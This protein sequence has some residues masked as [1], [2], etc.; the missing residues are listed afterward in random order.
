MKTGKLNSSKLGAHRNVTILVLFFAVTAI[1][2]HAQTFTT[3]ANFNTL[4]GDYPR[5]PLT[6]G[7]DGNFYGTTYFGGNTG[8]DAGVVFRITPSGTLTDIYNFCSQTNCEDGQYPF[9]GLILGTDG[10]FYGT[11]LGGSF[12]NIGT[13]FKITPDGVL[14][15]LHSFQGRDGSSPEAGLI[16][17]TDGNFY[18]TTYQGG[19]STVCFN[20][21]GTLFRITPSGAFTSLY[22][23]CTQAGCPDGSTPDRT[24]MQGSDGSLYGSTPSGANG[25][26]TLFRIT[27]AGVFTTIHR[28]SYKTDGALPNVTSVQGAQSYSLY[29]TTSVG[30]AHAHGTFF[31]IAA[32]GGFTTL[33][34]FCPQTGCPDGYGTS[35]LIQATDGNFYGT[36]QQGANRQCGQGC[37]TLFEM[38]TTGVL[39]TLYS[40]CPDYACA[41]GS[42]PLGLI[43]GTDGNF[44]GT[45]GGLGTVFSLSTG[46]APFVK[47]S[48]SF[49]KVGAS[50]VIYG[51][52]L[53][54]A[55]A[56]SFNG[57]PASFT[58]VSDT[59]IVAQ[60]PAGATTGK[61]AVTTPTGTLASDIPF[62]VR[63]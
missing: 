61:I 33:Y 16:E 50:I 57:T 12:G 15:T 37:G 44:Y 35:G 9:S 25:G 28:F 58:V 34:D 29:A 20:G 40:F 13:V 22:S 51:M 39:T 46:L 19:T 54:D 55:T 31:K 17:A 52:N 14:T 10:N 48:P 56:V 3:L 8:H 24:L 63:P 62:R 49:G 26:G 4:N 53:S 23:F 41:S 2:S 7:F 11:T 5:G 21:C 30:G 6:Q 36:N 18:G 38:T 27:L 60:I 32:A 42:K 1:A 43:Q 59:E 45:T 47:T